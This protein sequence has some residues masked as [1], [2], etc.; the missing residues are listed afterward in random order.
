MQKNN[1]SVQNQSPTSTW[2]AGGTQF[3]SPADK[4]KK[5]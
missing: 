4:K 2:K 1:S 5:E 3:L